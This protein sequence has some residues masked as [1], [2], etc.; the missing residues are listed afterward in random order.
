MKPLRRAEAKTRG[1]RK[2]DVELISLGPSCLTNQLLAFAL[3][4]CLSW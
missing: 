1:N 3:T 2:L 4:D